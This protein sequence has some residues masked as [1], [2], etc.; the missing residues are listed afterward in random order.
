MI[1]ILFISMKLSLLDLPISYSKLQLFNPAASGIT[2]IGMQVFQKFQLSQA[3]MVVS[4]TCLV[5]FPSSSSWMLMFFTVSYLAQSY[6]SVTDGSKTWILILREVLACK[7]LFTSFNR[8][9]LLRKTRIGELFFHFSSIKSITYLMHSAILGLSNNLIFLYEIY[10]LF[11]RADLISTLTSKPAIPILPFID[12][13][14]RH[15]RNW[16]FWSL[17]RVAVNPATTKAFE[18]IF[19]SLVNS[20]FSSPTA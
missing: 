5:K 14:S 20:R 19:S 13:L 6:K 18:V 9:F 1:H 10:F 4:K 2:R 12:G 17:L 11:S 16:C 15:N 3:S 7:L 8:S